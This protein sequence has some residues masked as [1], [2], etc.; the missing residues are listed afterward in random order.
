MKDILIGTDPE[1]FLHDG[2]EYISAHGYFPGTKETPFPVDRGAVQVDG[3]ALEFNITPAKSAEEFDENISTVLEQMK[4]MVKDV[5]PSYSMVFEP[6]AKFDPTYFMLLPVSSKILGC[7]PDYTVSGR[8]QTPDPE[9][10]E[11]PFRTAAG[12]IHIGWTNGANPIDEEH[13]ALCRRIASAFMKTPGFIPTTRNERERVKYY[14]RPGSF[15][16]KHYG[17]ELRSPSNLWVKTPESRKEIFNTVTRV[18][19][20]I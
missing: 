20:S 17:V 10:Q 15:R 5:N 14:G 3:C 6:Y 13:F 2:Q 18:M 11:S 16:P 9:L 12:H 8:M 1:L 19:E 4:D 7:D